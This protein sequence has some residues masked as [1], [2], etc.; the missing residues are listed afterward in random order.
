MSRG[1]GRVANE[2]QERILRYAYCGYL[3]ES[4][5][6]RNEKILKTSKHLLS[7]LSP[8][9]AGLCPGRCC[10]AMRYS[11]HARGHVKR[12]MMYFT[13]NISHY[14]HSAV[15]LSLCT[16][17]GHMGKRRY[18][19]THF[20]LRYNMGCVVSFTPQ[21]PHPQGQSFRY[22]LQYQAGWIPEQARTFRRRKMYYPWQ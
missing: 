21:P 4:S 20:L 19:Y 9:R 18:S 15:K 22:S 14:L 11:C 17:L 1:Q 16:P 6:R 13:C 12:D 8:P 2:K 10:H 3:T 7:P 5:G